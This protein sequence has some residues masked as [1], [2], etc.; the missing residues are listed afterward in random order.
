MSSE[1]QVSIRNL[2]ERALS[3]KG[4][5]KKIN[6]SQEQI[7][8]SSKNLLNNEDLMAMVREYR[9][10]LNGEAE[11]SDE[12]EISLRQKIFPIIDD[13]MR[14]I[15]PTYSVFSADMLDLLIERSE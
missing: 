10:G 11:L 9:L 6:L 8:L 1:N 7:E 5:I 4:E 12:I 13:E 15:D 14:R 2:F 3:Y